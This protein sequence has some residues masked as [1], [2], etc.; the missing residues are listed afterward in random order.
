VSDHERLLATVRAAPRGRRTAAFFDFDGTL[1]DGYSA[2]AMMQHRARRRELS[3]LELAR[4][5]MVGVEAA[6]GRADF[7]RFMRVGVQA[8]RGH[9]ADDLDEMGEKLMRTVLGGA[10]YPE[11]WE[12]V[13]A[14]RRR[15]HTVVIATSALPFQVEP[16]ARE[17]GVEHV[18]CTRLEEADGLLTGEVDGPILWGPGKAAAVA[19]FAASHRI[20][21]DRSFGYGNGG[22]D[23]DFL[24]TV[25]RPTALNPAK[26]LERVA[27][28]RGW[29]TARFRPRSRPGLEEV[30]RTVAS[31]GGLTAGLYAGLAVG[32]L[33]RSRKEGMNVT[34]SLGSDAGLALAGIRLNVSGEEHLWSERPAVF[35]FNHQSW[36]VGMIVMKLLR[37]DVTGVAKKEVSRQPVLAQI[38]WLMNMAYVDRGDT[39][40]A[41]RALAPVVDRI[42]QGI[43]LAISPEG[44]RSPTP[45][46]GPFKKGAFHLAMQSGVPIVPI[47]IRNAGVHL[48][49]GSVFM[50]KGTVDVDVLPP[51]S[52]ADWK[53]EELGERV[54]EVRDLF[55]RRLSE[56]PENGAAAPVARRAK[57]AR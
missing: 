40:Q 28:E 11:A 52:V 42:R 13:A 6:A 49:R 54:D 50:R 16:L 47:V 14:H 51:I 9:T 45:R 41:K 18:L 22:E 32:L 27:G 3:P 53:V 34:M 21:L 15:G 8:F 57:A 33:K 10:L 48:W 37:E 12:L 17:L 4:L 56:W 25:G 35:I 43:S 7:E 29:P 31:Y 19:E 44:T 5:L 24:A 23:V 38:G 1:I 36:L 55:V 46:V 30:A 39:E 26:Q 20:D 2:M